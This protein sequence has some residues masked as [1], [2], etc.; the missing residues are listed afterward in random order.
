MVWITT[1]SRSPL[2]I[3]AFAVLLLM[4]GMRPAAAKEQPSPSEERVRSLV[5]DLGSGSMAARDAA[6]TTLI[7][8]GPEALPV[9]AAVGRDADGEAAFRLEGIRH[10][11]EE[12]AAAR[13][14]A[15]GRV[16][17]R[18]ARTEPSGAGG[19]RVLLR[20]EW[21][22]ETT[23][24]AVR[25]PVRSIVAEGPAGEAVPPAQRASVL[26]ASILPDRRFVEIPVALLRPADPVQ[27]LDVLRGTVIVW[28][29]GME[30]A[31]EFG[32]LV[33][34]VSGDD[35]PTARLGRATVRLDEVALRA[36]RLLVTA[37]I[38]YDEPSE[39]L[40]SHRTWLSE[41]PLELI[42]PDGLP[43]RPVEQRVG[44]RSE[45]GLT[46]TAEFAWN[47]D[48]VSSIRGYSLRWRLPIAIHE[49]PLDFA[50]RSIP[51]TSR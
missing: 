51:L 20:I 14:S 32:D 33:R 36:G 42:G 7:G 43:R 41:R 50:V 11:L 31:F 28:L 47:D 29:G 13:A 40:A 37:S 38:A 15:E 19:T 26:E 9:I 4:F 48:A 21:P 6:E 18:C 30:H 17:V 1:A 12:Q 25:L 10:S 3:A 49:Q 34:A 23:L 22:E 5:L 16:T 24:L 45:R 39:A 46:A 8:L 27:S 2:G 44:E 35:R